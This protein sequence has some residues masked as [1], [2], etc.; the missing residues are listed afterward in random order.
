MLFVGAV[1][2]VGHAVSYISSFGLFVI[3]GEL[4]AAFIRLDEI[5]QPLII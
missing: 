2:S 1:A 5:R 4:A 3:A